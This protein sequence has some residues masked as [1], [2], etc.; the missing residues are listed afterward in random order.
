RARRIGERLFTNRVLKS[1]GKLFFYVK[2][3]ISDNLLRAGIVLGGGGLVCVLTG[4]A[5]SAGALFLICAGV[6]LTAY[7]LLNCFIPERNEKRNTGFHDTEHMLAGIMSRYRDNEIKEIVSALGK[8]IVP[9][10]EKQGYG[11]YQVEGDIPE[12]ILATLLLMVKG[13]E[14]ERFI[15]TLRA[16]KISVGEIE[17]VYKAL[18]LKRENGKSQPGMEEALA[19]TARIFDRVSAVMLEEKEAALD[20][21]VAEVFT[22]DSPL[23]RVAAYDM[24]SLIDTVIS[25][26]PP[27]AVTR[28]L[29]WAPGKKNALLTLREKYKVRYP[30]LTVLIKFRDSVIFGLTDEGSSLLRGLIVELVSLEKEYREAFYLKDGS[31][32]KAESVL[33]VI[34]DKA[35]AFLRAVPTSDDFLKKTIRGYLGSLYS[36]H[37]G[38]K[39]YSLPR[40]TG[41]EKK[42]EKLEKEYARDII[43]ARRSLETG[44]G[45]PAAY[46]TAERSFRKIGSYIK[47]RSGAMIRGS[48]AGAVCHSYLSKISA[49]HAENMKTIYVASVLRW[50]RV[51]DRQSGKYRYSRAAEYGKVYRESEKLF[52]AWLY[53]KFGEE[54]AREFIEKWAAGRGEKETSL[55][56]EFYSEKKWPLYAIEPDITGAFRSEI[57]GR[58]LDGLSAGRSGLIP[59]LARGSFP[60]E[61]YGES[62]LR[63]NIVNF[64]SDRMI[65]SGFGSLGRDLRISVLKAACGV[66]G[67]NLE[68]WDNVRKELRDSA[69]R[70]FGMKVLIGVEALLLMEGFFERDRAKAEIKV[71]YWKES[72]LLKSRVRDDED[73]T[74]FRSLE[75]ERR[76]IG[77]IVKEDL[78]ALRCLTDKAV[79]INRSLFQMKKINAAMNE[80]TRAVKKIRQERLAREFEKLKEAEMAL[81]HK[82]K[83]GW[84]LLEG[85]KMT[86][87]AV[88]G[89]RGIFLLR[90]FPPYRNAKGM[91][92]AGKPARVTNKKEYGL[93]ERRP[94]ARK[95]GPNIFQKAFS[96]IGGQVA[97]GFMGLFSDP[98][99]LAG[100]AKIFDSLGMVDVFRDMFSGPDMESVSADIARKLLNDPEKMKRLLKDKKLMEIFTRHG[101]SAFSGGGKN[102]GASKIADTL[103]ENPDVISGLMKDPGMRKMF[104]DSMNAE[105]KE[106]LAKKMRDKI[107]SDRAAAG[108]ILSMP[109]LRPALIDEVKKNIRRGGEDSPDVPSVLKDAVLF[110]DK[111]NAGEKIFAEKELGEMIDDVIADSLKEENPGERAAS[112]REKR[113]VERLKDKLLELKLKYGMA[114][115]PDPASKSG[116]EIY[117]DTRNRFMYRVETR[118]RRLTKS[119][120]SALI[121][122]LSS[123][124]IFS[125][126]KDEFHLMA[127]GEYCF[128]MLERVCLKFPFLRVR[129]EAAKGYVMR[130]ITAMAEARQWS[131]VEPL[132]DPVRSKY[133]SSEG[134][135]RDIIVMDENGEKYIVDKSRG[136]IFR[137]PDAK[138]SNIE[139]FFG[140]KVH[141]KFGRGISAV[142]MPEN[143]ILRRED[144]LVW[145]EFKSCRDAYRE[146][147]TGDSVSVHLCKAKLAKMGYPDESI[148]RK[149]HGTKWLAEGPRNKLARGFDGPAALK[150]KNIEYRF[151]KELFFR[152]DS[153]DFLSSIYQDRSGY[154]RVVGP[155]AG[156]WDGEEFDLLSVR[157]LYNGSWL[158][159]ARRR[160]GWEVIGPLAHGISGEKLPPEEKDITWI[161]IR[162]ILPDGRWLGEYMENGISSKLCGPLSGRHYMKA[163]RI[164]LDNVS[165]NVQDAYYS[166]YI[167]RCAGTYGAMDLGVMDKYFEGVRP[168]ILWRVYAERKDF[169]PDK[170]KGLLTFILNGMCRELVCVRNEGRFGPARSSKR[171]EPYDFGFDMGIAEK[172]LESDLDSFL[173]VVS[174]F[175]ADEVGQ[176]R[177]VFHSSDLWSALSWIYFDKLKDMGRDPRYRRIKGFLEKRQDE[178]LTDI[179][180]LSTFSRHSRKRFGLP[181]NT[182]KYSEIAVKYMK[183]YKKEITASIFRD[184]GFP[185]GVSGIKAL[186][187]R[188]FKYTFL[189][190]LLVSRLRSTGHPD[191]LSKKI[192]SLIFS[193]LIHDKSPGL[194]VNSRVENLIRENLGSIKKI[195]FEKIFLSPGYSFTEFF[196]KLSLPELEALREIIGSKE[197]GRG[198]HMPYEMALDWVIFDMSPSGKRASLLNGIISRLAV[199]YQTDSRRYYYHSKEAEEIAKIIEKHDDVFRKA[200]KENGA[201]LRDVYWKFYPIHKKYG[202]LVLWEML[203]YELEGRTEDKISFA[204]SVKREFSRE[205][206]GRIRELR[207]FFMSKGT[208]PEDEYS[209]KYASILNSA[210]EDV[211]RNFI[212]IRSPEDRSYLYQI[213]EQAVKKISRDGPLPPV[214]DVEMDDFFISMGDLF[215]KTFCQKYFSEKSPLDHIMSFQLGMSREES[216]D[217][218]KYLDLEYV[219]DIVK[220]DPDKFMAM[221]K[222]CSSKRV[223]WFFEENFEDTSLE[224]NLVWD[225]F[226]RGEIDME[227]ALIFTCR[228]KSTSLFHAESVMEII[229][230]KKSDFLGLASGLRAGEIKKLIRVFRGTKAEPD[231]MWLLFAKKPEK[232]NMK[233]IFERMARAGVKEALDINRIIDI[234]SERKKVFAEVIYEVPLSTLLWMDNFF[235]ENGSAISFD[236]K[237][238]Y[239]RR[240]INGPAGEKAPLRAEKETLEDSA[241]LKGVLGKL[242][243]KNIEKFFLDPA[244]PLALY[245]M[246]DKILGM[247][248]E[249][250][251]PELRA[252]LRGLK[253][254]ARDVFTAELLIRINEESPDKAKDVFRGFYDTPELENIFAKYETFLRK[255][256]RLPPWYISGAR[257]SAENGGRDKIKAL[258]EW[259]AG[260]LSPWSVEKIALYEDLYGRALKAMSDFGIRPQS[261]KLSGETARKI[262]DAHHADIE[263]KSGVPVMKFDAERRKTVKDT[264]AFRTMAMIRDNHSMWKIRTRVEDVYGRELWMERNNKINEI[265][266]MDF[267]GDSGARDVPDILTDEFLSDAAALAWFTGLVYFVCGYISFFRKKKDMIRGKSA[268]DIMEIIWKKAEET[269][270]VSG[271][272]TGMREYFEK[273]AED[274]LAGKGITG[275]SE[276][277]K[278]I[279]SEN[280]KGNADALSLF[281]GLK[282]LA[283]SVPSGWKVFFKDTLKKMTG[284]V[285]FV[286]PIPGIL[287][288][289]R[290]FKLRQEFNG[291]LKSL[292]ERLLDGKIKT[293]SEYFLALREIVTD[294]RYSE[295]EETPPLEKEIQGSAGAGDFLNDLKRGI[296]DER[297]VTPVSSGMTNR[298]NG[299][300]L[301]RAG[302]GAEWHE[303]REMRQGEDMRDLEPNASMRLG[304]N[305]KKVY[306]HE[307]DIEDVIVLYAGALFSTR[308]AEK[309][310]G[311]L[312]N[313]LKA[314]FK[315]FRIGPGAKEGDYR[316]IRV[317]VLDGA[318]EWHVVIPAKPKSKDIGE[319]ID[320]I[321]PA[322]LPVLEAARV[323]GIAAPPGAVKRKFY[324]SEEN[325]VYLKKTEEDEESSFREDKASSDMIRAKLKGISSGAFKDAYMAGVPEDMKDEVALVLRRA[326]LRPV[327]WKGKQAGERPAPRGDKGAD[328]DSRVSGSDARN[329][330]GLGNPKV[331][332]RL[333]ELIYEK[334]GNAERDGFDSRSGA[335]LVTE[336][337]IKG[338][339][340]GEYVIIP[341]ARDNLNTGKP[342]NKRRIRNI[343]GKKKE[344]IMGAL[345]KALGRLREAGLRG[346]EEYVEK[347]RIGILPSEEA[348]IISGGDLEGSSIAHAGK[349]IW[350]PRDLAEYLFA[351]PR[352]E[353]G[354]LL[355]DIFA[356]EIK[357]RIKEG[358]THDEEPGEYETLVKRVEKKRLEILGEK[359]KVK[360]LREKIR[361]GI[362]YEYFFREAGYTLVVP[363]ILFGAKSKEYGEEKKKYAG[364]FSLGSY[365]G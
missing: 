237:L 254:L 83:A 103:R 220:S 188:D 97:R 86:D 196:M 324:N 69:R 16:A 206:S 180:S 212:A 277:R 192:L 312:I 43:H 67:I 311:E 322:L 49:I 252:V 164:V 117:R 281:E 23:S 298:S 17:A 31:L 66:P 57:Y 15:S 227:P 292:I 323:K 175:S 166:R 353:E 232:K 361:G 44:K 119:T 108:K 184:E 297:V 313:C 233:F 174:C 76:V 352:D 253:P 235:G 339:V 347:I 271:E 239:S 10:D 351:C 27:S 214:N 268:A 289:D 162:V 283:V 165:G 279:V 276:M 194:F 189:W 63:P 216:A 32:A 269:G 303:L 54:K 259:S 342:D 120:A 35:D 213:A 137:Y 158:G 101:F 60:E 102:S 14:D 58:V 179:I 11:Y 136:K 286:T 94:A 87:E 75:E 197:Y 205:M 193:S 190:E 244:T 335:D 146:I 123:G 255:E 207:A 319:L 350:L 126:V 149:I 90:G 112:S 129:A 256:N 316:L 89:R 185:R 331:N 262:F 62:L 88:S 191:K 78:S 337:M 336:I 142:L 84:L 148:V 168:D 121:D 223:L 96:W 364:I 173:D 359:D 260:I 74:V 272:E 116:Y 61:T 133:A 187:D 118:A 114:D 155:L 34:S 38:Y 36:V 4:K 203:R 8:I 172:A 241:G 238:H 153:V 157:A 132:F 33:K 243:E 355:A 47:K 340:A 230:G 106:K 50:P 267:D 42:A 229:E 330:G 71:P 51:F 12:G 53:E 200:L 266:G 345:E 290:D 201:I 45:V 348:A 163:G 354:D 236:L 111:L 221:V 204:S 79:K 273:A 306:R 265:L 171:K 208:M 261:L 92:K 98:E 178:V 6:V 301:R 105:Q 296:R 161:K 225:L 22:A 127:M 263:D 360:A 134:G 270:L 186:T 344:N 150:W 346:A 202:F 141:V 218:Y 304:K 9:E 183:K 177:Q 294:K 341:D 80:M 334:N 81:E 40:K 274:I 130:Q 124:D 300:Q 285:P 307:I 26:Y 356:H 321:K 135:W 125:A 333:E 110:V 39:K 167:M 170:G 140:G 41:F 138:I 305:I 249:L 46:V 30:G 122:G 278:S 240:L 143:G 320:S 19:K 248:G 59:E 182:D 288:E 247:A 99:K 363:S 144:T 329:I 5:F 176:F 250:T 91:E 284:L 154:W 358:Y 308:T 325:A 309:M 365:D 198:Y 104:F 318:G 242:G 328:I 195:G 28:C 48:I 293:R 100:M 199:V 291:R 95:A 131:L 56:T 52:R 169:Y 264:Y 64:I 181:V 332:K 82:R 257:F 295:M 160:G 219:M 151:C 109:G 147:K 217:I 310:K 326:G 349:R 156:E 234:I 210:A 314:Q 299:T 7:S 226:R 209:K 72:M 211:V 73:E 282:Y 222:R 139:V 215:S 152:E 21:A 357:H 302:Q 70:A 343:R 228:A 93:G 159:V 3:L 224:H 18:T 13:A 37:S 251:V 315:R 246:R 55:R 245:N 29:G 317:F 2:L 65:R 107:M 145:K 68:V 20:K 231:L 327:E 275:E 280:I 113:S 287:L 24:V 128:A 1:P 85:L 115:S 77:E 362:N 338:G 25:C 258:N